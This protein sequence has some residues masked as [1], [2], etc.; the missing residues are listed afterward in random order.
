MTRSFGTPPL[1]GLTTYYQPASWGVWH[2]DAAIVPGTYIQSVSK[3]GGT[4]VLLPPVG[5][6]EAVLDILDGLIIIGGSDVAPS[7]YGAVPHPATASQDHRDSHDLALTAAAL[8][9]GLP[10]FAICRGAQILNVARGGTLLQH[11]P[12]EL[13]HSEYQ[14]APGVYGDVSFET[15]PGSLCHRILG[16]G[17][18]APV[19]HHQGL[20]E[21]GAGLRVTA[22]ATDGTI[23]A[24][25]TDD[26]G[27]AVG[28]QFHPEQNQSDLRLFK[29]FVDA[30]R[31]YRL[32]RARTEQTGATL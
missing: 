23:E 10:L 29:A 30:A 15:E 4:P 1:I 6:D 27:W 17:A 32:E 13:G 26:D 9:R 5:T 16:A 24:V 11:L 8:E 31:S 12:D 20:D 7:R 25:E 2:T 21:L 3:A 19:Y 18:T 22:R 14:P 28:V